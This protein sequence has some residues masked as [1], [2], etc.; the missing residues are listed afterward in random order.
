M[1]KFLFENLEIDNLYF[2]RSAVLSLFSVGKS[3]GIVVENSESS[4]EFLCVE[5]SFID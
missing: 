1:S 2:A 5:D 3:S 4:C